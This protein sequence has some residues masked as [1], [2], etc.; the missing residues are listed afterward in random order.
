MFRVCFASIW[1]TCGFHGDFVC[2]V[3]VQ[4]IHIQTRWCRSG[5]PC[6]W[7]SQ[8]GNCRCGSA[9]AGSR[10]GKI[11]WPRLLSWLKDCRCITGKDTCMLSSILS[12]RSFYVMADKLCWSARYRIV[13]IEY[14]C[15]AKYFIL[16]T[17]EL[18]VYDIIWYLHSV[19]FFLLFPSLSIFLSNFMAAEWAYTNLGM[20]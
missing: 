7:C 9:I 17:N 6:S 19:F 4:M 5:C 10:T 3:L 16:F 8:I 1:S 15:R 14:S 12:C 11:C 13:S 2:I 18:A 20:H